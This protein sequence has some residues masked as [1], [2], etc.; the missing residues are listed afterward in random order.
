MTDWAALFVSIA[1]VITA[2]GVALVTIPDKYRIPLILSVSAAIAVGI[3]VSLYGLVISERDSSSTTLG[4]PPAAT[5]GLPTTRV[6]TEL[7]NRTT[8]PDLDMLDTPPPAP[9]PPEPGIY[10]INKPFYSEGAMM[11][12]LESIEVVADRIKVNVLYK[13][14]GD[15]YVTLE[16]TGM[17]GLKRLF[18]DMEPSETV[19]AVDSTCAHDASA[20]RLQ[21]GETSHRWATFPNRLR[22]SAQPFSVRWYP[23]KFGSGVEGI[24]LRSE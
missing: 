18:L 23:D 19:Y 13:N 21:T 11:L 20:M 3:G 15:S 24:V 6:P 5:S 17:E 1:G 2:V 14:V 4:V 8:P 16:C 12:T 9:G 22:S 10:A 7:P